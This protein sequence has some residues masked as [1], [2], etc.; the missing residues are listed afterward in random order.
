MEAL[1]GLIMI[2]LFAGSYVLMGWMWWRI[3]KKAGY[4]GALGILCLVPIVNI[5]M[6]AILAFKDWPILKTSP[7]G[8]K[9]SS[10]PAPLIAAIVIVAILPVMALFA[11]IAIPSILKARLTANETMAETNLKTISSAMESYATAHEGRYPIGE[12]DLTNATPPYLSKSFNN[13]T[14]QGYSYSFTLDANSYQILAAPIECGMTGTRV[15]I[16]ETGGKVS[17]KDC[18]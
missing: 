13:K 9:P 1:I 14:L 4:G 10:L 18:K 3:F 17:D 2:V 6:L 15:F 16:G 8:V 12:S 5:I 11:A 7:E